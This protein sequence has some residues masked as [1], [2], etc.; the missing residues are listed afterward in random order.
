MHSAE[1]A[2]D[3]AEYA[4]DSADPRAHLVRGPRALGLARATACATSTSSR[5]H[6][7]EPRP[8]RERTCARRRSRA[9]RRHPRESSRARPL[10]PLRARASSRAPSTRR[11]ARARANACAPRPNPPKRGPARAQLGRSSRALDKSACELGIATL[12][13]ALTRLPRATAAFSPPRSNSQRFARH[14][15]MLNGHR[16][17]NSLQTLPF[18]Y[19]FST[20]TVTALHLARHQI[21]TIAIQHNQPVVTHRRALPR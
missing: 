12:H 4:R 16:S 5:A 20:H 11:L 8:S 1:Y 15:I 7:A 14:S 17:H 9:H 6:S 21:R 13:Q 18:T 3:S 19:G 10:E 2:R